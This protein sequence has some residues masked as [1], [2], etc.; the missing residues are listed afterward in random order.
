M[1]KRDK[2][3]LIIILILFIVATYFLFFHYCK[4]KDISCW[5]SNLRECRRTKYINHAVDVDWE[6]TIKGRT[7]GTCEVNVK[8]LQVIR[9]MA[10][11]RDLEGKSMNCYLVLDNNKKTIIVAPE[12][13]PNLCHGELKEDLQSLVI[14]NLFRYVLKNIGEITEELLEIQG[15][16]ILQPATN[17]SLNG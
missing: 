10:K 14:E 13:N 17:Q 9:G 12:S 2:V 6:Y 16:N 7:K 15:V 4:C 11:T 5:E 8:A 1:K 3:I